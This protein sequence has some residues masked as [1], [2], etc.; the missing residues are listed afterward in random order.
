MGPWITEAELKTALADAL[1]KADANTLVVTSAQYEKANRWAAGAIHD[2]LVG[3]GFGAYLDEWDRRKEFNESLALYWLFTL[4]GVPFAGSDLF[5]NK[6]DRRKELE[7]ARIF[8]D[9][10]MVRP[11]MDYDESPAGS[12]GGGRMYSDYV[13][14]KW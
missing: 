7:T 1:N 3:R 9:G 5:V 14:P 4:G 12:V 8:V 13:A 6:L 11:S 10:V 2:A